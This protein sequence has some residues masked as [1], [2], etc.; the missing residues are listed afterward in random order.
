MITALVASY[1]YLAVFIGT[2]L[3][4]ETVLIAAGFAAHRGLLDWP[5]VVALA[6]AGGT[7]GDLLAFLLG[8]WKGEALLTRFPALAQRRG[9]IHDLLERY[10]VWFIL[11]VRFMYGLRIAGPVILGTSRIS[12]ARFAALNLIGAFIWATLIAGAGYLFGSALEA[13]LTD[14]HKIEEALLVAIL[15]IGFGV[16]LWR[17]RQRSRKNP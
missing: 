3:E 4:G 9:K 15:A 5:L 12:F 14:M 13:M 1:G 8:R 11:M 17:Q 10:D 2:L 6:I 16:W 7:L